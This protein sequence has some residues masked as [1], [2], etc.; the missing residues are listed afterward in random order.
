MPSQNFNGSRHQRMEEI[1][2]EAV[3]QLIDGVKAVLETRLKNSLL[4]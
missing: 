2:A 3:L 1:R 4:S